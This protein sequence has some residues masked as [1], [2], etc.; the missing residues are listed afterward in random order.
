[1]KYV[2][3]LW[4]CDEWKTNDSMR[5]VS[6]CKDIPS[7]IHEVNEET[8]VGDMEYSG[9]HNEM[10]DDLYSLNSMLTYGAITM[11]VVK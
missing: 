6:V 10:S 11:E 3:I 8:N 7:L 2:Y 4:L 9:K 5:I 1:M